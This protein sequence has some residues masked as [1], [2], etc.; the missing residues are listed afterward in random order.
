MYKYTSI[1][2]LLIPGLLISGAFLIVGISTLSHYGLNFDEPNHFLRGQGYLH[3]LITGSTN[4]SNLSVERRSVWQAEG[5]Y[6][7]RYLKNDSG[8]P[9][10]NGILASLFNYIFYQK[11]GLLPDLESYHLFEIVVS[12]LTVFV[13]YYIGAK[14]YGIF[15]GIIAGLSLSLYPMFLGESHFNVKDPVEAGFFAFVIYFFYR[16]IVERRSQFIIF[17][18]ISCGFALG[19]KFNIVFAP[20]IIIPW[21]LFYLRAIFRSS[22]LHTTA[23]YVKHN[24]SMITSL[25]IYPIISIGMVIAL[26]PYLWADPLNRTLEIINYYKSIGTDSQGWDMYALEFIFGATPEIILILSI[27]GISTA[28]FRFRREPGAFSLL[29][30]LWF[31]IPILRVIR[32]GAA[33]ESGV[34]QIMEYV[35]P[36]ALLS[37]LGA[38]SIIDL[39]KNSRTAYLARLVIVLLFVQPLILLV[40][41]H[42]NENVYMNSFVG[43]LSG[44]AARGLDGAGQT[45]GDVYLQGI[46]WLNEHAEENA[47]VALALGGHGSIPDQFISP[48][49]KLGP[50]SSRINRSGEYIM[51]RTSL[52]HLIYRYEYQILDRFLVPVHVVQVDNVPLLKIWKNSPEYF[53]PGFDKEYVVED[54]VYYVH[55]DEMSGKYILIRVPGPIFLTKLELDYLRTDQCIDDGEGKIFVL[56]KSGE[57]LEMPIDSDLFIFHKDTLYADKIIRDD[58]L[59]YFF[60]ATEL[61]ALRISLTNPASCLYNVAGV[62]MEKVTGK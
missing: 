31:A 27:I 9:P 19:T 40:S 62:R 48:R 43:G 34:R 28:I 56:L 60:P 42:P 53:K 38:K 24:K 10:V 58:T 37:G 21:I 14:Q 11:L 47:K 54:I 4:Y 61:Y 30:L 22:I 8:H 7:E 1:V 3:Y 51:E 52:D 12:S 5:Y 6:A 46:W 50:Y 20:F 23:V 33:I 26:W 25:L 35:P 39:I 44:A 29:L 41:L 32:P 15:A 13:V 55:D 59:Y 17:S 45:M 36:M 57:E 18:A 49:I 2:N 16:G